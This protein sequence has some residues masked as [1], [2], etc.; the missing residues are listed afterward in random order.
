MQENNKN[1]SYIKMADEKE[2]Y[3]KNPLVK[4]GKDELELRE[5]QPPS[6]QS[7]QR[8]SS[9]ADEARRVLRGPLAPV[10]NFLNMLEDN[11][12]N[13]IQKESQTVKIVAAVIFLILYIIYFCFAVT[14]D[15]ERAKDLIYVT[16]FGFFC[17]FYWLIKKFFGRVIWKSCLKPIVAFFEAKR[18]IF[19][20]ILSL[21]FVGFLIFWLCWDTRKDPGRLISL[22]GL[23]VYILIGFLFSKQRDRIRWRPVIWGFALQFIF[24]LLIL[25]TD[26][27]LNVFKWL[28][29][30]VTI[31]LGFS[32][33][34]IEFLFRG[35]DQFGLAIL[36]I[37][38]YFSAVTYVLYYLGWMQVFIKKVAWILQVT[39]GTSPAESVNAAGNIFIGQTEAPLLIRPFLEGMTAS[40]LHAVMTGGFATIAG[41][42]LATYILFGVS[43]SH[44]LSASVMSAPAAL[45]MSKLMYPETEEPEFTEVDKIEIDGTEETNVFEALAVGAS[46]S[47]GLVANIGVMIIAFLSVLALFD[48]LLGWFGGMVGLHE[49]SFEFICSYVFMPF[50]FIMGVDYKDSFEVAKMLGIKTFLNEFIAY[51]KLGDIIKNRVLERGGLTMSIRSEVIA[52][53]ALCGFANFGSMGVQ[54][55]GISSLAPSKRTVLSQVVLRALVAGTLACFMTAC[56]AGILYDESRYDVSIKIPT[57]GTN[58]TLF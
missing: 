43:A 56:V 31:F 19:T 41:S 30:R 25:R 10:N 15:A 11:T 22:G 54:I 46:M 44:L 51:E 28:G 17:L 4:N 45:A 9:P 1:L 50:A 13:F 21:A 55:G 38:V 35:L 12:R 6:Y 8:P 32:K 23:L 39:M 7:V 34:G 26:I 29:D 27:G 5:K 57:N 42:V 14:L 16:V 53:Y 48:G 49:L 58:T 3:E 37:I 40:E 2:D 47:I 24:G 20:W 33:A 36:P 52:T 18:K